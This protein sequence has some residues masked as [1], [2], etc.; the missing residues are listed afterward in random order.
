M[1]YFLAHLFVKTILLNRPDSSSAIA[2]V[3]AKNVFPVPAGPNPTTMSFFF[4][5]E[6]ESNRYLPVKE[7]GIKDPVLSPL[8]TFSVDVDT[9]SYSNI[10]RMLNN[11]TKPP[12][13]S[14]RT[15]E[16]LNYFRYKTSGENQHD[17]FDINFE[18]AACPWEKSDML[19]KTT[20]STEETDHDNLPPKNLVFLIDVSGSM[21][22][23][24][25][26]PL[27]KKSLSLLTMQLKKE[28]T[29]SIVVYASSA[30]VVLPPTS[31]DKQSK[32][33]NSLDSLRSG[34]STNG[35]QG[36]VRAYELAKANFIEGGNC[37]NRIVRSY[38]Q[39]KS[40]II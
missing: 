7:N 9:V 24:N 34:G 11:G 20:I 1:Q 14:V 12:I 33:I 17:I 6:W 13:D 35:S 40:P 18:M 16:M 10:R 23:A 21:T 22:D 39:W 30:G 2:N 8:S 32:I 28:D 27:L 38:K 4:I 26:L 15:E 5:E 25:K 31:G 3:T 37:H 29:I 19:L 36:I